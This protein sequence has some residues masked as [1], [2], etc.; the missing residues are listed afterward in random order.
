[1]LKLQP[2]LV[3]AVR[4]ATRAADLHRHLQAAMELEHAT[5][6]PYLTALY[7]IKPGA[8]AAA[9]GIIGSVVVEEMLHLTIAGNVLNAIGGSPQLD[10][11]GFIPVFPGPLPMGV[12]AGL[13]VGLHRLTRDL[14][15]EAFMVIEE[16]EAPISL[17]VDEAATRRFAALGEP[18]EDRDADTIGEFYRAIMDKIR[19]LGQGAFTGDPARQVVGSTWFPP[20]QLFPVTTVD[21]AV[22]AL[23]VIVDQ[24]EGTRTSPQDGDQ[25]P[26]HYYRFAQIVYGRALIQT[27]S[28]WSYSGDPVG[29][30]PAGVWNLLDDPKIADY[31]PGS[32]AAV[33]AEQFN[34]SYTN[35][36]RSLQVTFNGDPANLKVA[37]GLMNELRLLAL[38]VVSTPLPGTAQFAAPTFEYTPVSA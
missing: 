24:G 10:R 15:A 33:L 16:P 37:I 35:L 3:E 18:A 5:I 19:Q 21:E 27:P 2:G 30:D 32:R 25:E 28:G 13:D 20:D 23:Q 34:V 11:P 9:S 12:H 14:V 36:L 38:R 17:P 26:A 29:V 4:A 8:N 22:R 1:M 7:S 6:P 31:Q